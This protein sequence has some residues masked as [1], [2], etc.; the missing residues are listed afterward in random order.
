MI[1]YLSNTAAVLTMSIILGGCGGGSSEPP[2]TQAVTKV[3]LFGKMSSSSRVA[4][5]ESGI[6]VP[7][8]IMV[9]YSSPLGATTGKYPLRSGSIV[10]SG[11]VKFS[12]NDIVFTEYNLSDRKLVFKF[13][14]TPELNNKGIT[15][16][17]R[18]GTEGDGVEVATMYFILAKPN[19]LPI[20]PTPWQDTAALIGE[21]S[22]SQGIYYAEGLNLNFVTA[23]LP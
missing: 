19:V 17:I 21:D 16:N 14:N 13:L 2:K 10:P 23:F 1:K 12:P 9:N 4:T 8:G 3:Y 7:D 20:L 22:A 6:T 18:S 11:P 5:I 15:K